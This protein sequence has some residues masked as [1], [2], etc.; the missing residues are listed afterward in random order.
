MTTADT[1]LGP[2]GQIVV[3]LNGALSPGEMLS[4]TSSSV[5]RSSGRPRPCD[6][7][8]KIFSIHPV[9]SRHGVHF[10]HDSCAKNFAS[11]QATSTGSTVSSYTM[12]APEPSITPNVCCT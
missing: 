2:S 10:P 7:R 8:Y 12:I 6:I 11:R 4:P 3:W 5:S 1:A 9:P